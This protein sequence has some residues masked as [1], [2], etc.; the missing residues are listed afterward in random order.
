MATI[1]RSSVSKTKSVR[2]AAP[3]RFVSDDGLLSVKDWLALDDVKPRYELIDGKLVQKMTTSRKHTKAAGFFLVQCINWGTSLG[4]QFFP[5]GTGVY[6][7]ERIGYV[8]D[9]VGF[10]PGI[11][12]D[13][14]SAMDGPPYLVV[15]VLSTGTKNK[16]R[17]A[18]KQNYAKIGIALYIIIDPDAQTFEAYRL[19]NDKYGAPE[20]LKD[21]EI[22]QPTELP[23]LALQLSQLWM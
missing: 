5:E 9:V 18:K 22:W 23:G 8:P 16:D 11:E 12:L 20:T 19:E 10:K 21:A 7:S 6:I 13:P 2:R 3:R 4:W 15:E 17:N 1:S 14:D